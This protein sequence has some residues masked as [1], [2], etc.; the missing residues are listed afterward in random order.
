[1]FQSFLLLTPSA[2]RDPNG[3]IDRFKIY[4]SINSIIIFNCKLLCFCF[5]IRLRY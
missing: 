3:M 5:E 1:M 2:D 4:L